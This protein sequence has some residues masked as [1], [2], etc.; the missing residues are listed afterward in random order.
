MLAPRITFAYYGMS[1][2]TKRMR[3]NYR[4]E[5]YDTEWQKTWEE[6][7][8][9]E[10]LKPGEYTFKVIAITRDLVYSDAL[11]S[12]KIEVIADPRDTQIG[13]VECRFRSRT[14]RCS[15]CANVADA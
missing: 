6:E 3:Y 12:V 15:R 11:A 9:Y 8:S 14:C 5:G 1:F 13:T 10:N 4:L 7:A 2:K